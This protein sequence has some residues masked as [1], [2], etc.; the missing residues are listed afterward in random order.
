MYLDPVRQSLRSLLRNRGFTAAAVVTLA[1]GIGANT[2]VFSVLYGVVLRPLPYADGDRLVVLKHSASQGPADPGVSVRE[3]YDYRAASHSFSDLVEYHQM[4][5]DLLDQG[6]PDRVDVG[7]VSHDFFNVL[8]I[9]PLLGRTFVAADD[10]TGAEAVLVLSHQYW[11][12]RFGGDRSIV[13]RVFRMND[14]THTVIGVLPDIAQYPQAN[15]V[16]MPVSACPFRAAAE[17]TSLSVRRAFSILTVFGKL[18]D[19]LTS[20]AAARDIENV[21]GQ[22]NREHPTVYR[23]EAHFSG[24]VADLRNE[25]VRNA[26]PILFVLLGTTGLLLLIASANVANLS[27]ARLLKRE[28]ELAVKEAIGAGRGRLVREL[29]LE[30]TLLSLLGGVAGLVVAWVSVAVLRT[31]IGRFTTRTG[32]VELDWQVLLFALGASLVTGLICGAL[33]ALLSRT[34]L[35]QALRSSRGD[36]GVQRHRVQQALVVSQVAISMVLLIGAGLLLTSFYRLLTVDPGYRAERVLTAEV[37]GNFSKYRTPQSLTQFYEQVLARLE[38]QT[39]IEAVSVTDAVPLNSSDPGS[40]TFQIQGIAADPGTPLTSD[41]RQVTPGYFTTLGIPTLSGRVFTPFD[42]RTSE[43][44]V[45]VNQT[46]ARRY[47]ARSSAVGE[48]VSFDNGRTWRTVVGVV[49]DVRQFGPDKDVAPQ[50]YVPL[51][52]GAFVS[53]QILLRTGQEPAQAI[54]ALTGAVRAVD[55][56]MPIENVQTLEQ[57]REAYLETPKATALLLTIFAVLAVVVSIGGVTGLMMLYV[58]QRTREFGVRL[59]LGA[60][61]ASVWGPVLLHG[62][63]L[64]GVG[65]ALGVA[66]ALVVSRVLR[67]YLYGTTPT[68]PLTFAVVALAFLATGAIVCFGPAW[69]ATRVDPLTVLRGE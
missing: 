15:D 46:M 14:R 29:L 58:S 12:T 5:F 17:K 59:A 44:V 1:L 50:I 32:Q 8:G 61:A 23:P 45:V 27:L 63:R 62:L 69:R 22:F 30:S 3:L 9:A 21:S 51:D 67:A 55:P 19:G 35:A 48:R 49:G 33:P 26:R 4:N 54:R 2:A 39:G 43:P 10:A 28:R 36:E 18:A 65:L 6:E 66:G 52:Q 38:N 34:N 16:Y 11:Q 13:G 42:R 37:F 7:V 47:W 56:N 24:T 40:G 68:D 60:P 20:A 57:L 31:F 25:L 41:R 53:G 64:I